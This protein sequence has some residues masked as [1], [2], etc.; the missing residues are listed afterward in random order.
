[1]RSDSLQH[2]E[3]ASSTLATMFVFCTSDQELDVG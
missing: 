3:R 1:V 2:A